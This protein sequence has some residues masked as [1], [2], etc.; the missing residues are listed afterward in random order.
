MLVHKVTV[1]RKT[2]YPTRTLF[3]LQ[4]VISLI[5][6][7]SAEKLQVGDLDISFKDRVKMPHKRNSTLNLSLHIMA[8]S[9]KQRCFMWKIHTWDEVSSLYLDL[10]QN[11]LQLNLL[12]K[13]LISWINSILQN[14]LMKLLINYIISFEPV[15]EI[16]DKVISMPV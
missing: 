5:V 15:E 3:W 2:T 13:W 10:S 1:I 14:L 12:E 16:Y 6:M 9:T 8:I 11:S 4:G 7:C